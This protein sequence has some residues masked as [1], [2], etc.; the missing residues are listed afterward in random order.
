[1]GNLDSS[2]VKAVHEVLCTNEE[3][4]DQKRG[5]KLPHI[6]AGFFLYRCKSK[7][8]AIMRPGRQN[9]PF[10]RSVVDEELAT[11][12]RYNQNTTPG[13]PSQLIQN[14]SAECHNPYPTPDVQSPLIQHQSAENHSTSTAPNI[15]SQVIQHQS[16]ELQ[17]DMTRFLSTANAMLQVIVNTDKRIKEVVMFLEAKS[18]PV[19]FRHSY[20]QPPQE[21]A[22]AQSFGSYAAR[23]RGLPRMLQDLQVLL[24]EAITTAEQAHMLSIGM[25]LEAESWGVAE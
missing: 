13:I 3:G 17:K 24:L 2:F 25:K 9:Q 8:G 14:P 11:F 5:A 15:R 19:F 12:Q 20:I 21:M 16:A 10:L 23:L 22:A 6:N 7:Y 4:S 18:N 1:M